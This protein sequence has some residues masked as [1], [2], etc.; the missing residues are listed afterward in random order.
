MLSYFRFD[1]IVTGPQARL[2]VSL[3]Q[4]AVEVFAK[5]GDDVSSQPIHGDVIRQTLKAASE[6]ERF[7]GA[8]LSG[9]V[10][11]IDNENGEQFG[12]LTISYKNAEGEDESYVSF[13]GTDD[14][15]VGWKE[16]FD[17]SFKPVIPSQEDAVRYLEAISAR[18]RGGLRLGG[19]SKGG[20]LAVFAAAFAGE[21]IQRR[22][23]AIYR[24]EAPGFNRKIVESPQYQAVKSRISTFVP[25]ESIIGQMF[26]HD[27]AFLVVKSRNKGMMQHDAYSWEVGRDNFIYAPGVADSSEFVNKTMN[28]WIESLSVEQRREFVDSLFGLINSTKAD[29][30]P[31][32]S[33]KKLHNAALIAQTLHN[34]PEETRLALRESMK[35][36]LHAAK[37]NLP[38]LR[39]H[40][41]EENRH[42]K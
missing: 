30:I 42:G 9:F 20:N 2:S 14:S 26:E 40:Q 32:F 8:R 38:V 7:G 15:I 27:D 33:A 21:D 16:D 35:A 4:A 5:H 31:Q 1:G 22:I 39:H 10:N 19:H 37:D 6:S 25:E 23:I 12:A 3:R 36:L 17:M 13:R 24:N 29:S 41:H 18:V 11:R 28:Q 34:A